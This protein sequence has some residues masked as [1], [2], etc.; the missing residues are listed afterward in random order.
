MRSR[1]RIGII[2]VPIYRSLVKNWVKTKWFYISFWKY[3][4]LWI[5]KRNVRR[6]ANKTLNSKNIS[7]IFLFLGWTV[8]GSYDSKNEH[9]NWYIRIT[10]KLLPKHRGK[11]KVIF[12]II[13]QRENIKNGL[14]ISYNVGDINPVF[15]YT[16][17]L[18]YQMIQ[19]VIF[20]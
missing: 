4:L 18:N 7:T 6:H 1:D 12:L 2:Y 14:R 13:N 20:F 3:N 19:T 17:F 8:L 9:I 10:N 5:L 11:V 15:L 16:L